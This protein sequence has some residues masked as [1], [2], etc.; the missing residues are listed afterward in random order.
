MAYPFPTTTNFTDQ[1]NSS[2]YFPTDIS[3]LM[4]S[5][6]SSEKFF[7]SQVDDYIELSIFDSSNNLLVWNPIVQPEVFRD[8][9]I[10][11]QD[12]QN[13]TQRVEYQEF[14]PSFV[15]YQ[16]SKILL[17][18]KKDLEKV[19]ID[20]GSYKVVYNFQSNIVGTYEKK[21]IL[22]KQVSANR[23]EIKTTL[24]LDKENFTDQDKIDFRLE[25]DCF[26]NAKIEAR[27]ILP[28]FENYLKQTYLLNFVNI[29]SDSI[30]QSFSLGYGIDNAEGLYK[31]LNEI[32]N[33]FVLKATVQNGLPKDQNFIGI[34]D[35]IMVM[36]YENYNN[37]YTF[38]EYS[39]ILESIVVDVIKLKLKSIHD[40]D[41]FDTDIC[42]NYLF[43]IFN[44]QI[45]SYLTSVYEDYQ[46]K[47][48]GPLK[49]S[50]NFGNNIFFKILN[51]RVFSDGTLIIKLEK[52]LP[53]TIGV[54]DTFWI[55]NTSLAP[56]VQNVVLLTTPKYN[57]FLIKPANVNLKVNDK[58][59][60]KSITVTSSDF[61][62]NEDTNTDIVLKQRFSNISVDYTNF[63]NFIVY[64]SAKTRIIVYLNKLRSIESKQVSISELTA[65]TYSDIYVSN[66]I[67]QLNDEISEIKLSFDGY[68]YY[69]YTN[70]Y[71][72]NVERFPQSYID[73]A[74]EYDSSNRDNLINNLPEYL[75]KDVRNDD[76]LI[77]LSMIGHHFD[78]IYIYVDKFPMLS[79]NQLTSQ[80]NIPNKI[81]D[82]MLA[83]FG[84]N[85][86][87]SVN[88]ATLST[89]YLSGTNYASIADK[90][91]IINNRILNSLPA[92][93]KAKG[94]VE[95]VNLLLNCYGVPRNIINVREFGSYSD[96]SQ[97]LY[98]FN[99]NVYLLN[100]NLD[101]YI[102]TPYTSS[103]QTVEFKF[104]F[105]NRYSKSYGLQSQ[106]DLLNKYPDSMSPSD[107][108]VY[109]Y[110]ENYVNNGKIIFSIGDEILS[111][112]SLPIFDGN[113]YSV[114]IRKNNPS[115]E[116]TSSNDSTLIPTQYDLVVAINEDGENRL[117]SVATDTFTH[118][119]NVKF[120]DGSNPYLV[121]GSNQFSGS[122]DKVNLW[123]TPILL[124]DFKEHAN[125]FDSYHESTNNIRD[126]LYFRLGYNYPRP[127]SNTL[128]TY[129]YVYDGTTLTANLYNIVIDPALLPD[130]N[131]NSVTQN[132]ELYQDTL[133]ARKIYSGSYSTSSLYPYANICLDN[134]SSLFPYNFIEY[135][136]NQSYRLA[137]YGPNRL[138]NNKIAIQDQDDLSALTPFS[139]TT[140][141]GNNIDSPLVG[142]V[143]SPVTSKNEEIL[144]YF[145]DTN[146]V[147]EIGDPRYEFSSSYDA[148]E[149]LRAKYYSE[150]SPSYSG[151]ILYQEFT[152]IYKLY[153]DSSIFESI[154][155][156]VAARNTLLTGILIEPS[157]IE[158][159]KFP[160]KPIISELVEDNVQFTNL[161][162]QSAENIT[163]WR[164]DLYQYP[165]ESVLYQYSDKDA[166]NATPSDVTHILNTNFGGNYIDD[167]SSVDELNRCGELYISAID[168]AETRFDILYNNEITESVPHYVWM[169][170]YSSSV[171]I[172]NSS[173]TVSSYYKVF[174]KMV[175]TPKSAYNYLDRTTY[176][177][178]VGCTQN[179]LGKR[180][181]PVTSNY[182]KV[183]SD[184]GKKFGYFVKSKQTSQ[185]TVDSCGNPDKTTPVVST[186]VTNT[187]VST[188]NNGVLTV[189]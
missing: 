53:N 182:F 144:R 110:K 177:P 164:N 147:K 153:F 16:N 21:C 87:S 91:N 75:L 101:S 136:V 133:D 137:N 185:Y 83:S 85:M 119:T 180:N 72:N 160:L 84:W 168:V 39:T 120:I 7:G 56:I 95:S 50:I 30:K 141:Y 54:N 61:T 31:L 24:L 70:Q 178:Y 59:T 112:K 100:M 146:I 175:V 151:K 117:I 74:D 172:I 55:S 124:D 67:Q 102:T 1:V 86:Q 68:E 167:V 12:I 135:N 48:V 128:E 42:Y 127:I 23:Q 173:G 52:P 181:N 27:D 149:Q 163:V 37:C 154:R 79:F 34:S 189:Q 131:Y 43:D 9:V 19:G 63:Q 179:F 103:I 66:K 89:N 92:I 81:L 58:P 64:S 11:Y 99:K 2:S 38:Q 26:V 152:S 113:V 88:D 187:S 98:T 65:S 125:N 118:D 41:N 57:T 10:E 162:T 129:D 60:S 184:D 47:Y 123:L 93:L 44:V 80:T 69:L 94:T 77:F 40:V 46:L 132:V 29:T 121:F 96:V 18:P 49:N 150:G 171:E 115:S 97:S 170:P 106:I 138:W 111:T 22:I 15:L 130:V 169:V 82:G 76:F 165:D 14:I 158:R 157:I 186:I 116:Y 126:Y 73:A 104:A 25:Y 122:I 8:R 71:Y 13:N 105:S 139:K 156:V 107:Y 3:S 148:L 145:G 161:V 143:M 166:I 17:D 174:K 188:N 4:K 140:Q 142:V 159:T 114:M 134:T 90:S 20:N 155:N 109:A 108:R 5:N 36:L 33:G 78:N 62:S 6:S 35:N 28:D 51:Q 176:L 183:I 32:Y 45:Q